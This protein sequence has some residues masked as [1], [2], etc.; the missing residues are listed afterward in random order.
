[1][2]GDDVFVFLSLCYTFGML[3]LVGKICCP[4]KMVSFFQMKNAVLVDKVNKAY[5]SCSL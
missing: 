4:Q 1:M 3:V 2:L 5:S